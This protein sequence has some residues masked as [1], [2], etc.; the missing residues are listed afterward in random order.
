MDINELS[1]SEVFSYFQEICAIPHGSGNTGMIADYCLDFA[2]LHG[3]KARK[4]TSDNVV[5]FKAGSSGY[6]DCEPVILQGHLDMVCEKEPGCDIDMSVQSIKACT[7]GKMVWADG[8][9]LGADDGIA[10][11]FILAVL[12]SDTIA[13]PPIQAVLTSD[14]EIGMLGARDLDTSDLT[15]KRLI[16]IDS[17]SEGI[18]YVSCAG[19]VRAECDIPVV[20][21]DAADWVAD[22][23]IDV[24]NGSVCFEAK[25]S[26]L[27]GGHSGVEIHKQHTN[28]IRLLASLLS[29]A[30]GA[31]DF[32]L[33]SLS[34]GGKENA[35]PKEAK[36]EAAMPQHLNK[37]SKR[38]RLCGCRKSARQSH[39]LRLSLKRQTLQQTRFLIPRALQM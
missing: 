13:H 23:A 26:G 29:H 10:V 19:G 16:N 32:R 18:L 34:G 27:A 12:A 24:Q 14:E 22:G 5:I 8:T 7:D 9:T 11:A 6:E 33:V 15:A 3:L 28:A 38:V 37:A 20:Y 21:E 2:K 30:S 25:I 31:A 4:D 35:I 36:A 1:P 17:E 39:M